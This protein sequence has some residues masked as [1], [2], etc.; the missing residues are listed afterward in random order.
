MF[1]QVISPPHG[2]VITARQ[3]AHRG[4]GSGAH[5]RLRTSQEETG[6]T[7]MD[8]GLGFCRGRMSSLLNPRVQPR[9][10]HCESHCE[11]ISPPRTPAGRRGEQRAMPWAPNGACGTSPPARSSPRTLQHQRM[12]ISSKLS[13]T[14]EESQACMA[15]SQIETLA[16][17]PGNSHRVTGEWAQAP[18]KWEPRPGC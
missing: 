16:T 11:Q 9:R 3:G 4:F 18:G 8:P 17:R 15:M 1:S 14:S 10:A 6:V 2:N 5:R 12:R 7:L 13:G